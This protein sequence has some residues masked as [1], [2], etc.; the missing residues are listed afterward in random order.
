M[1]DELFR[2]VDE[3][4]RQ[5]QYVKLWKQYGVY[6]V[7]A[8]VAI[9][10][11]TVGVVL[12]LDAQQSARDADGEELLAAISASQERP[13]E[14]L[15]GL[16]ALS[17]EGTPGYR[18]L[19]RLR[20]GALLAQTGDVPN[21]VAVYDALA[22]DSKQDDIYRDLAKIL[23]VSHGMSIMDLSEVENR[24][25]PLVADDNPWRHSARE[26]LA[27]AAMASGDRAAATE[28]FQDLVDDLNAPSGIRARAAEMLAILAQ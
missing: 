26:L 6:A 4:V 21:A 25:T 14:A 20:E 13:D 5:E 24:L 22:D 27:T 10:V 3:E 15:D 18:L 17:E 1:S 9:I 23:A 16:A 7:G 12:W 2:E 8:V 11:I 19:A 28:A